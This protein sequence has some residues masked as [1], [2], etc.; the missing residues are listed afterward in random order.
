MSLNYQVFANIYDEY[1]YLKSIN[2]F[3]GTQYTFA[4]FKTS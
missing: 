1:Y 4:Y 3:M 2:T